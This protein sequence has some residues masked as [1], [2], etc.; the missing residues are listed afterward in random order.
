MPNESI[1]G[2]VYLWLQLRSLFTLQQA[3][4][5]CIISVR[6]LPSSSIYSGEPGTF[7]KVYMELGS[8]FLFLQE[9]IKDIIISRVPMGENQ[10]RCVGM[11]A[12]WQSSYV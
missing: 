2:I 10:H 8:Y 5:K 1:E 6:P 11:H 7:L 4:S 3:T 12:V 9:Q